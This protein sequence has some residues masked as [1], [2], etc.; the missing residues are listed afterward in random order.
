MS[1]EKKQEYFT[2]LGQLLGTYQKIII[3][4][5][6]N[7]GSLQMQ[8][9]RQAMR[10][11]GVLLMG[12]NTMVRKVI[13]AKVADNASLDK[14]ERQVK[15]N[16][17]F[18]FCSTD[19]NAI[20]VIINE[21]K[22]GAPAKAGAISPTNVVVPAGNTGLE[23]S[24]TSFFQALNIPTK[25]NKGTVEIMNDINLITKGQKVGS[26]E[27]ALLA[28]LNITPFS[29]GLQIRSIYDHGSIYGPDILDITED[30]MAASFQLAVGRIC[31][32]GLQ[33]GYPTIASLPHS[34]L[35][36]FKN[37][38]A[39]SVATDFTFK[40]SEDIKKYLANPSAFAAPAAAAAGK[41]DKKK[42]DKKEEKKEDKKKEEK[43]EEEK[44]EEEEEGDMGFGLFD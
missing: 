7:V 3:V 33:I 4:E 16:V 40:Q 28:K 11:K 2:K 34:V 35:N 18:I 9:I 14:L 39:I 22:K 17:G 20:R 30:D 41:K 24:Q 26:S 42:E 15:G 1:Q 19:F 29:Y 13:R 44:K 6:D 8:R 38:L 12:K 36:A 10:G 21:N 23:P 37:L 43:K 31:Q 25:I 27:A 5:A 32:L